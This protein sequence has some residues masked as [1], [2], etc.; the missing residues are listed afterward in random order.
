MLSSSSSFFFLLSSP[1]LRLRPHRC[2]DNR[3]CAELIRA[4]RI[5]IAFSSF[6]L[7]LLPQSLCLSISLTLVTSAHLSAP[8]LVRFRLRLPQTAADR[9]EKSTSDHSVQLVSVSFSLS[10]VFRTQT[11]LAI[12]ASSCFSPFFLFLS[13]MAARQCASAVQC[14][15]CSSLTAVCDVGEGK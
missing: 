3:N 14:A 13:K 6:V 15:A 12:S 11:L 2:A 10:V 4:D 1:P 5:S 9:L 7:I 8:A